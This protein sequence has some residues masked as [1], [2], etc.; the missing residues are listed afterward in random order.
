MSTTIKEQ[1]SILRQEAL[2][3]RERMDL[4]GEDP[5]KASDLFL[6]HFNPDG[7]DIVAAYWP[8]NTEFDTSHLLHDLLSRGI[9]C[10]LP[11]IQD[12]SRILLF[13]HWDENVDL[14]NNRFGIPEPLQGDNTHY[15]LP[16]IVIVPLLAFDRR[17]VRLG[18]GGGYYDATLH[19]LKQE[20]PITTVGLAYKQQAV[21]FPLPEEEHDIRLDY[22][23][24]PHEIHCYKE[25]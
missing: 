1:K 4:S 3:H 20:K 19:Y 22:I 9:K 5:Q 12:E 2:R 14:K 6:E 17:G 15:V 10:A 18:Y 8:K 16:D 11:I 25:E 23:V 24:T 13:S 21:L 7:G